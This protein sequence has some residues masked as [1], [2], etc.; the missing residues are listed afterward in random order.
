MNQP[1]PK[2]TTVYQ[3]CCET[4]DNHATGYH[5]TEAEAIAAFEAESMIWFSEADR[6]R[7]RPYTI[8]ASAADPE[9]IE[10]ARALAAGGSPSPAL[11]IGIDGE[12]DVVDLVVGE[13]GNVPVPGDR[14]VVG[15][16]VYEIVTHGGLCHDRGAAIAPGSGRSN[17]WRFTGRRVGDIWDITED[18][19]G[20]LAAAELFEPVEID[21]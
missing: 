9:V 19:Y 20:D 7:A 3:A 8:S 2:Q 14:V 11:G 17:Y 1:T 4:F 6:A 18:E 12:D 16:D 21:D 10:T 5:A 13:Q 15:E